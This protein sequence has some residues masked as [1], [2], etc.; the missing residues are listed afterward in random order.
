MD[1][2]YSDIE[3]INQ[4]LTGVFDES[5]GETLDAFLQ[6]THEKKGILQEKIAKTTVATPPIESSA[7]PQ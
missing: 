1:K 7:V 5:T 2:I 6:D 3:T 4:T